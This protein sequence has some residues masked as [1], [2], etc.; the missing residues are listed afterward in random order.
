M[1]WHCP[2]CRTTITHNPTEDR[3]RP[4]VV[5]RCYV[6][7]LELGFNEQTNKLELLPFLYGPQHDRDI[8]K[9]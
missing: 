9:S 5:Y 1:P 6:C 3:P 2:A 8:S 7:R 4:N